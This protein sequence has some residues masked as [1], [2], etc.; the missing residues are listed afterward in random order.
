MGFYLFSSSA[1]FD[2][3]CRVPC[4]APLIPVFFHLKPTKFNQGVFLYDT[5]GKQYLDWTSQAVCTNLGHSIPDQVIQAATSQ[6][7]TLPFTYSGTGLTEVRIR[8]N[9]LLAEL[10]PGDLRPAVYPSSG[11]E[12][13]EAAILMARRYTSRPKILSF[14]N[15]YHGATGNAAS[16]TGDYRRWYGSERSTGF[17]KLMHPN[18]LFFNPDSYH[19]QNGQQTQGNYHSTTLAQMDA[20]DEQR[21]EAALNILEEQIIN[22]GPEQIASLIM[23]SVVGPGG[24][25]VM[26]TRYMQGVR[27]LCNK[28]GILLHLDEVMVGFGRTGRLFGFQH[29]DGVIPDIMVA[30]KGLTGAAVP[31]S[32]AACSTKI[33]NYF[34]ENPLGWGSTYQAHPVAMAVAYETLKYLVRSDV[35]GHVQNN[36]APILDIGLRRLADSY[37][38]IRQV[39]S[40]GLFGCFDIQDANGN[41]PKPV[42]HK[43]PLNE[44]AFSEYKKAYA[45]AGLVGIHRYPLIHSAPPLVITPDELNYGLDCLDQALAVLNREL[46]HSNHASRTAAA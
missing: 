44:R 35:L 4:H 28:Y 16:A 36:L 37:D 1:S 6:L 3:C 32:L 30:G 11:A 9:Q 26:P 19:S 18:S 24:C 46:G 42:P 33:M 12:A 14:Y 5:A 31:L 20:I 15:S 43:P 25:L 29:Y 23:E 13:N 41:S 8:L 40:I 10:L 17:V 2:S 34:E 7:S 27:A 38:C 45:Q 21:I 22:E 39:R